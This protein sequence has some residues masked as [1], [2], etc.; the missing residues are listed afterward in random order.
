MVIPFTILSKFRRN[1]FKNIVC[2]CKY[3]AKINL[4][5]KDKHHNPINKIIMLVFYII[6]SNSIIIYIQKN[7]LLS[8]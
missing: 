1:Y 4:S 7:F 2:R 6:Y 5:I 8:K 3:K